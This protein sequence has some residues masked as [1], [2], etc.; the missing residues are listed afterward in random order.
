M[1]V[2]G[3]HFPFKPRLVTLQST[4]FGERQKTAIS[5]RASAYG[6]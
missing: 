5:R 6:R 4:S 1:T 3:T 2:I